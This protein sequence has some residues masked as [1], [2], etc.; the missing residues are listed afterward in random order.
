MAGRGTSHWAPIIPSITFTWPSYAQGKSK[1]VW[2]DET[3][4]VERSFSKGEIQRA[5]VCVWFPVFSQLALISF[6]LK[7]VILWRRKKVSPISQWIS[8]NAFWGFAES[9]IINVLSGDSLY[10][11]TCWGMFLYWKIT[12]ASYVITTIT[13][14]TE[15][16]FIYWMLFF[17]KLSLKYFLFQNWIVSGCQID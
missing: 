5:C 17:L 14:N 8:P 11:I 4:A 13:F 12:A 9:S 1:D 7:E 15:F 10:N 2:K 6:I 16:W 3:A